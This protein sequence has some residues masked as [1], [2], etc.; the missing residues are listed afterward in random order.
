MHPTTTPILI[1]LDNTRDKA[2]L[3]TYGKAPYVYLKKNKHGEYIACKYHN[4]ELTCE[5]IILLLGF[6]IFISIGL[7]YGSGRIYL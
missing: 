4:G 6:G 5:K 7:G 1:G 3:S 2:F